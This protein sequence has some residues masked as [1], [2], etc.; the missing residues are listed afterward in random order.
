MGLSWTGKV[1]EI[2]IIITK[3]TIL[4]NK[5][6]LKIFKAIQFV[7]LTVVLLLSLGNL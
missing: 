4:Q 7:I 2:D 5:T 6:S 3:C 1:F